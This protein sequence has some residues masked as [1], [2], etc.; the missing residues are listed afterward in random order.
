MGQGP[1]T[2][3]SAYTCRPVP[4]KAVPPRPLGPVVS[5]SWVEELTSHKALVSPP[6]GRYLS[7]QGVTVT[8]NVLREPLTLRPSE[9]W[10][11]STH[12]WGG[13][14]CS[15][16]QAGSRREATVLASPTSLMGVP[17]VS[18][19]CSSCCSGFVLTWGQAP[20]LEP[21]PG[22]HTAGTSVNPGC[23]S[24]TWRQ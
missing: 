2:A 21:V 12:G 5:G 7:G 19:L 10:N 9:D 23:A 22:A 20:A 14:L 4:E 8:G 17:L 13:S 16:E 11:R 3:L 24:I 1:W 15:G 6:C 18:Y